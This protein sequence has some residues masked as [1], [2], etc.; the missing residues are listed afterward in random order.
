MPPRFST[1]R[2][3]EYT[4]VLTDEAN[5][6]RFPRQKR[7]RKSGPLPRRRHASTQQPHQSNLS[8]NDSNEH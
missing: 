1:F 7:R 8:T 4:E 6:D 3:R 2:P 5:G